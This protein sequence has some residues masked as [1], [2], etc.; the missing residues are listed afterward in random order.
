MKTFFWIPQSVF[1][2]FFAVV[3]TAC[4]GSYES[5]P[6]SNKS[7]ISLA[8][9]VGA[10][11]AVSQ[12]EV[13]ALEKV[14]E[15]RVSRTIYD[16]TYRI[17][18]RNNGAGTANNVNAILANVPFG[19]SIVDGLV[20]AG[21]INAGA[22]LIPS[23]EIVLRIDRT[24]PFKPTD[25]VWDIK[26]ST[27]LQMEV[28]KPAEVYVLPLADLGFPDGADSVTV[29]GAVSDVLLKDGTLRF[30]TPG[31]IGVDQHAQFHLVRG[32][33]T[34]TFDLMIHTTLPIAVETYIE[35]LDDGSLPAELPRLSISGLG[36]NNLFKPGVLTFKLEGAPIMELQDDSDGIIMGPGNFSIALKKYWTFN[37]EDGSFSISATALTELLSVLPND[38]LNASLNFVSKDGT[39]AASYE[40]I[41]MKAVAKVTG[42]LVN[43][44]GNNVTSLVGQKMLLKGFNSNLRAVVAV[45]ANGGFNFDNIIPDTYQITL[46]DLNNPNVV[47]ISALVFYESTDV[48]V[49]IIYPFNSAQMSKKQDLMKL[50]QPSFL[51]GTVSQN[52]KQ[53]PTR[54]PSKTGI[55]RTFKPNVA[56]AA[57]GDAATF[58][59]TAGEQNQT[60][61]TSIAFTVPKGTKNIGVKTT[62]FTEEYPYY[63]TMQSQYNDTWSYSVVGLPGTSLSASDSVNQSHYTQGTVSK[64]TCVDVTNQAKN[65]TL[66]ITGSV[67]ATNIGDSSLP[68]IT[69]VEI[70]LT[71]AGLKVTAAKFT[72]PNQDGHPILQPIRISGNLQGPY[73]SVSKSASDATHTV[74]LEIQYSPIDAEI[75]EVNIGLLSDASEPTF[76]T[77]NFLGQ[78]N[79]QTPGKIQFPAISLPAFSGLQSSGKIVISIRIKGRVEDVEVTS[80]PS[81]GGQVA[82]NGE[83]AFIPLYLAGNESGLASRRYGARD[84]GGDS[85]ATSQVTAWLASK[86]YRFD[87]ISAQHITQTAA[88]RSILEHSGHSDG[89]Q[90]D[91]RYADGQGGYSDALGG[92]SNGASIQQLINEA[93]AEVANNSP[94][95]P[96]LALLTAWIAANRALLDTEAAETG[97]RVIYIGPTFIKL[98]LV[99]GKFSAA[100]AAAIPGVGSWTKPAKVHIDAAHLSHWHLSMT[101]HP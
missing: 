80:D 68:T 11:A 82:F 87:D 91:M 95:K 28:V 81:E 44:Q 49:S 89:Q 4:G 39:F 67:S 101:A 53:P 12:F 97:T 62:I 69:S 72:S 73:I 65:S 8:S 100:A 25:L 1:A 86:A 29:S 88:G 22:T 23:D 58:T 13:V 17:R 31:D 64:T 77:D 93:A 54:A 27:M 63:T 92:Q 5:I 15:K 26:S 75:T 6:N 18:I 83:T 16:F 9:V 98:A 2:S 47:S 85:W 20:S 56:L 99:D 37:Q 71:C 61:T 40:F 21:T 79:V 57:A 46:A 36:P 43:A 3:L 7:N 35:P 55:P 66:D 42:Q 45:D 48:K 78:V 41:V 70:T 10:T 50:A 74:P 84:A 33:T 96:K 30:S 38:T 51:S 94:Q 24:I 19:T 52:G 34:T 32:G 14:S 60:I 59:A 76:A 90:I